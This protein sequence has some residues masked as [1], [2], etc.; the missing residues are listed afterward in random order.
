MY[1]LYNVKMKKI[2]F[3]TNRLNKDNKNGANIVAN[4]NYNNLL[5]IND[6]KNVEFF[7]IENKKRVKKLLLEIFCGRL[8][9]ISLFD[10]EKIC[11]L[12]LKNKIEVVFL[13]TSCYGFLAHKIKKEFKEKVKI[14]TFCH[15]IT[16]GLYKSILKNK[17][18]NFKKLLRFKKLLKNSKVNE[19][20][21][22][23]N[24]DKIITLNKRD[25][26]LLLK[27]YKFKSNIEIPVTFPIKKIDREYKPY[28]L[29]KTF[30][31]LFVGVGGFIPNMEGLNFFVKEVMPFIDAKLYIIG[32]GMENYREEYEN[33]KVIVIGTVENLDYYYLDADAVVAP[34]FTG[35]GMKVKTAEALMYGKTIFGTTEAFEGYSLNYDKIG[36]LCNTPTEFVNKINNY[37]ENYNGITENEYSINIF[38]KKYSYKASEELF[39]KILKEV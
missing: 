32:R 5:K 27:E 15:E 33:D 11:K 8:E 7:F 34:I 28:S 35:G 6:G 36:G 37:I 12:I 29:V 20:L 25:T 4:R 26:R 31:L 39:K 10:E 9:N 30:K 1:L 14:I 3:I 2:L 13:D 23:E 17:E 38:K 18:I 22:F 19:K 16:Q 24:S 21:S